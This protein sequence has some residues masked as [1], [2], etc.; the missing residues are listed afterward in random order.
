MTYIEEKNVDQLLKE[1]EGLPCRLWDYIS[2]HSRI[3]LRVTKPD[4]LRALHIECVMSSFITGPTIID[5]NHL[6]IKYASIKNGKCCVEDKTAG[7]KID[8]LSIL[9]SI[10]EE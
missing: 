6:T 7:L 8:C 4:G 1:W 3:T 9:V 5:S 10:V 2:T